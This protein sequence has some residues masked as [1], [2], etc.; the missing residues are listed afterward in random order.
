MKGLRFEGKFAAAVQGHG[1]VTTYDLKAATN[2]LELSS[3]TFAQSNHHLGASR[4][5][6]LLTFV[7][8]SNLSITLLVN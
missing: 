4:H 8:S 3:V 7:T 5:H 1:A 6:F 2:A